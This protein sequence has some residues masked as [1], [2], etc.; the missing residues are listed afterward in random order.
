MQLKPGSCLG[1]DQP[2]KGRHLLQVAERRYLSLRTASPPTESA[3]CWKVGSSCVVFE[4]T[5]ERDQEL[6]LCMSW[7]SQEKGAEAV[8]S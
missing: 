7:L 5:V 3:A 4:G 1:K 6:N 8:N 2:P